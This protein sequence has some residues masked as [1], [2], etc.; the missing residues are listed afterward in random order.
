[1]SSILK[2]RARAAL[3]GNWGLAI[4]VTLIYMVISGAASQLYGIGTLFVSLPLYVSIA[5]FFMNIIRGGA[6]FE[7]LFV[8]FKENYIENVFTM[9][10]MQLYIM[11]WS[12][13]LIIP[14]IIKGF[15]YAMTP[16]IMADKS[17]S[18]TYNDAITESRRLMDG[19]KMDF[20]I[21]QL[22]FIGWILLGILTL[23]ILY[24]WLIPYMSAAQAAFYLDIKGENRTKLEPEYEQDKMPKQD[25][26]SWDY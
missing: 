16:Y 5:Y 22:S 14:G 13:L 3:E 25:S 15:S 10:L 2:Q 12:F 21:L 9:F 19:R 1:M 20:F 7:D 26:D 18:L 4:G 24:I 11:L 17:Y 6:E 23:G 8:A